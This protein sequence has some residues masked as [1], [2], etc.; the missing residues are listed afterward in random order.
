MVST[1]TSNPPSGGREA[2]GRL[3]AERPPQPG[4]VHLPEVVLAAVDQGHRD[5][6]RVLP[7]QL[8][9]LVDVQLLPGEAQ[10]PREP[11]HHRPCLLAEM[12]VGLADQG[13]QMIGG[14]LPGLATQQRAHTH[15]SASL[16]IPARNA[17]L[18]MLATCPGCESSHR[19]SVPPPCW[20]V[21]PPRRRPRPPSRP[22]R[23]VR[24]QPPLRRER[25]GRPGIPCRP[26]TSTA[27]PSS[28]ATTP[29]SRAR[30]S[31]TWAAACTSASSSAT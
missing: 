24:P 19:R 26:R 8:G 18:A 3:S 13:D 7:V 23:P 20:R 1:R 31:S 30:R 22:T 14:T 21:P 15:H 6:L 28:T 16:S 4:L 27:P 25:L 17:P 9:V 2:A 29:S 5:L 11:V 12:A 10:L